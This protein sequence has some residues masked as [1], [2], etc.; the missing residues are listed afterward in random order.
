MWNELTEMMVI[1][2]FAVAFSV[3]GII[4]YA[5]YVIFILIP[6]LMFNGIAHIVRGK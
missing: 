4:I 1:S 3:C 6:E 2:I 5:P